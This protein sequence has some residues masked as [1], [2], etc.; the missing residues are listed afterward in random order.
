MSHPLSI[1]VET[2]Q[3]AQKFLVKHFETDALRQCGCINLISFGKE[4]KKI[5]NCPHVF[6]EQPNLGTLPNPKDNSV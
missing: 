5:Y 3:L 4:T 1:L 6:L 2:C